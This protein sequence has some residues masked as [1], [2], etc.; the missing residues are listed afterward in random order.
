MCSQADEMMYASCLKVGVCG[1]PSRCGYH[2]SFIRASRSDVGDEWRSY[3]R[4]AREFLGGDRGRRAHTLDKRGTVNDLS[5]VRVGVEFDPY[6]AVAPDHHSTIAVRRGD[7][8]FLR[9]NA[10]RYR[11]RRVILLPSSFTPA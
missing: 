9:W 6:G 4:P 11:S 8:E 2:R 10:A 5:A 1:T 7:P 3:T